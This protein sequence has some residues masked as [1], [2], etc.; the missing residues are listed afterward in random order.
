[1]KAYGTKISGRTFPRS[2]FRQINY[3]Q[4]SH[5]HKNIYVKI[6]ANNVGLIYFHLVFK[7][8]HYVQFDFVFSL[9]LPYCFLSLTKKMGVRGRRNIQR[10]VKGSIKN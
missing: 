2:T 3:V 5:S 10:K 6:C 8:D 1:M 4:S 7:L 9:L